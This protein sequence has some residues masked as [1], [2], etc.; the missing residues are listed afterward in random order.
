MQQVQVVAHRGS[1]AA[2]A[3]HTLAAYELALAEGADALECDVRLTRDGVLVC[4]HD[5]KVNRTSDGRGVV[6]TLELAELAELD[7]ASWKAGQGD[8][9]LEARWEEVDRDRGR[10][11]TLERLLQLVLDSPV[12]GQR[13]VQLHIETKHPTRYGGLVERALVE[14]LDRYSVATPLNRSVSRVVVMSFAPTSLRRVHALAPLVPTVMLMERVPVRYR[15]GSLPARVGIAGVSL[16]V[17]KAHPRYVE[18]AHAAGH[19]V[20]VWVV[21]EPAD[22]DHVL[23]LGVDAVISNQPRRVLARLARA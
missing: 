3:E 5:R 8:Q 20:H 4:V 2:H 19:R 23:Q 11:L 17:L 15:D 1:S 16:A 9:L 14:L 12:R 10:V 13:P 18:R 22:I 7:F 6:S 21:D